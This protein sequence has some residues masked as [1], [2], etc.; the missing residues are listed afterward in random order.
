[1]E[2]LT[3]IA[4]ILW[5][6]AAAAWQATRILSWPSL[7]LA[8]GVLLAAFVLTRFDRRA[9]G[10]VLVV[11]FIFPAILKS[12]QGVPYAP[13]LVLWIAALLGAMLPDALRTPWHIPGPWRG[14]L[15]FAAGVAAIGS[16]IVIW[17][18]TDG[19]WTLA[20]HSTDALWR[21]MTP[22]PFVVSWVL[23]T[24]LILGVGILWFD[25]L[26]GMTVADVERFVVTPLVFSAGMMSAVSVYQMF[27]DISLFNETA[28]A[29][30]KR[31]TG[32]MYDANVAGMIAA[33]W[34]GGTLLWAARLRGWRVYAAPVLV[35]ADGAAVWGSGSR[36]ALIAMLVGFA[37]ALVSLLLARRTTLTRRWAMA[38][39]A[40]VA[41]A[42][43]VTALAA[44]PAGTVNPASRLWRSLPSADPAGLQRFAGELWERNGYG[45]AGHAMIREFPLAGV[46]LGSFHGFV[47]EY[48]RRAGRWLPPDNAQS[49]L[50][51]QIAELGFVGAAGWIVW[52]V[53]FG[54][55]V[56]TPHKGEPP[57]AWTARGIVVAFGVL[58]LLAMPGQDLMVV[59]TFW[60]LAAWYVGLVGAPPSR[61]IKPRTWVV[62][63]AGLAVFIAASTSAAAG[64]LRV[65]SRALRLKAPLSYGFRSAEP[66]G[67]DAGFRRAQAKAVALVQATPPWMAVVVKRAGSG[68]ST[69][70]ADVRVWC[71][72]ESIL[73]ATLTQASPVTAFVPVR[74]ADQVLIE[75][76]S[77]YASAF[78]SG[79]WTVGPELLVKWEFVNNAPPGFRG[80][81][82]V[83]PTSE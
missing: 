43:L 48:G 36:S 76:S 15:V 30:M 51:Q 17:R 60:T 12:V 32:T 21:G 65:T 62:M 10:A 44:T 24:A 16:A 26:C 3:K 77:R 46:G 5:V 83:S 64:E 68:E 49:W 82:G 4:V 50:R 70:P 1:V 72:G 19:V 37:S 18:E 71:N 54:V 28:F 8:A 52:V 38:G 22:P 14:A 27:V 58:S 34:A 31:A 59:I 55:F 57:S 78:P 63:A 61:P 25:W 42:G 29:N 81:Q 40:G 35:V 56:L 11:A 2:R 73:K 67:A 41:A 9:V 75:T 39:A 66:A 47:T 79:P 20:T 6:C 7:L 53:A 33:L 80:Y 23:H 13:F 74:Q 45:W 69:V